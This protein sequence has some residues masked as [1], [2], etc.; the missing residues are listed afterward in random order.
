[1]ISKDE[2]SLL[3]GIKGAPE[4]LEAYATK[5]IPANNGQSLRDF[6]LQRRLYRYR[7]RCRSPLIYSEAFL[8]SQ[9]RS[10]SKFTPR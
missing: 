6:S 9:F 10:K 1:V 7:Y 4:F 2:A 8:A 5:R 3:C